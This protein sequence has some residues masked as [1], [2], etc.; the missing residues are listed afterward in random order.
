VPPATPAPAPDPAPEPPHYAR[1]AWRTAAE[2]A[3][4]GRLNVTRVV[5]AAVA[6][7]DADGLPGLSIRNLAQ[8]L[9]VTPMA[10]Y[11]H[12]ESRDELLVLMVD[13]ALGPPPRGG[14]PWPEA[15]LRWGKALYER[16]E[17][18]PWT[19][20]A[21]IPGMPSTPRLVAWVDRLLGDLESAGLPLRERLDVALLIAGH[22]RHLA[23]V[24]LQVR[25]MAP[26]E[27][28]ADLAVW[29]PQFVTP[30]AFPFYARALVSGVGGDGDGPS[31]EY[32][33]H[34]I[35]DGIRAVSRTGRVT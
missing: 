33:L 7:A 14:G 25:P 2:P 20:E 34:R 15:V 4:G 29:L 27:S 17:A 18:H 16:H 19:L 31:L 30:E 21:P 11:R 1:Q 22:V 10:V 32:G 35:I 13:A 12:V 3:P 8:R 23:N 28:A 24:R 6:L 5:E 9:G 26:A